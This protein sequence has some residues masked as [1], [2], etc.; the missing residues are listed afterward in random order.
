MVWRV[1]QC[2]QCIIAFTSV[3]VTTDPWHFDSGCSRHMAGNRF[4][5]SE[6]K[7][8]TSSH[9]TFGGGARGR[10]I[11]KG[12][13]AKNNLPCLKLGHIDLKS[14]DRTVK[15]EA[16]IGVPNIDVNSK[17]V[18]VDC[19]TEKQSQASHKS[20][21]E[22]ST[23]RVLELLHMDLMGSL[24]TESLGGK[25]YVSVAE[26]DFSRFTWVRFFKDKYDTP[27]VCISLCLILQR[28]K[29]VKIV[30][31]RNDHGK[32]FK[33]EDLNNFC[34]SEGIHHEYYAPITSQQNGV[35]ERKN[36]TLQEMAQ[37]MLHAKKKY[38]CILWQKLLTQ[39]VT[40]TIELPLELELI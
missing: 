15:N 2:G 17:L 40:F 26:E 29:G 22:C 10:I 16:V 18:C 23:N 11:A 14:I 3:Q 27:K 39:L 31:I 9:V 34:D 38:P 36:K 20:L 25:K 24:Q 19:L 12:N 5:F 32:E 37:V 33:N 21:K 13:I 35:V 7:E 28:E 8:C 1:K 30:R 4:F 6:L